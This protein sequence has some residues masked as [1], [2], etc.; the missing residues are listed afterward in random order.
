MTAI[1]TGTQRPEPEAREREEGSIP[2]VLAI[3]VTHN[4]RSWIRDCLVSLA[5]QTYPL[6]D[7]LVVDDASVDSRVEPPLK[8]VVKRHLRNRRWGY[9]RTARPL[10]FGGA[11]NWALS[12]VR[13]DADVL[14]FIHDDAAL[15]P[16]SVER[17]MERLLADDITAVVGPKIV[18]WDDPQRL[19]EVGMAADRFGYPYKG[20]EEG[21]IDLGQHDTPGEVF[22]VTSTCMLVRHDVF[23]QMR[24]WDSR[25]R[26][27]AEDLDLCWRARLMGLVVR[28][29]PRARAR[30][31]IALATSQRPSPFK[32][33]RYYIR[34]NRLRTVFKNASTIRLLGLVPQFILLTLAEMLGFIV[35]RQPGE[36]FNLARA[37]GWNL[38]HIPQTL[39]ERRRVQK[40]RRISDLKLRRLTVRQ[41]KRLRFYIAHQRDRLEEGWGR[42]A[43]VLAARGTQA[44]VLGSQLK[45]WLGVALFFSVV[46][47]LIG[48]RHVWWSPQAA[49][50]EL[51]PY[52]ENGTA[53][54]QA[55]LSP[56][57]AV[58]LGQPGDAP[59]ALA[60]L[61]IFPVA[62]FGAAGAAQKILVLA[63][64][65]LAFKGAYNLVSDLV[66]R[67]GRVAAG[68]IYMLGAVG[69]VG[70]REGALG[71]LVF[72][73][74]APFVLH[75]MVRLGGWARPPGWRPTRSL[76]AV[77]LGAAISAAFV[78]GSLLLYLLVAVLV[79]GIR[80][81]FVQGE[82]ALAGVILSVTG[83][84]AGWALLL[85]WSLHWFSDGGP[86]DLLRSAPTS[87]AYAASFAEHGMASVVLGQTPEG[88]VLF[89]LALPLLGLIAVLAGRGAR[90]RLALA[91]WAVIV[92]MGWVITLMS[93]GSLKP[94]VASPTE[95]G[96]LVS[97]C[98]A[99]LVGLSV[100]AFRLD[101]P[102]RGF[103]WVHWTTLGGFATAIFLVV[104]G[105]GPAVLSGSWAPGR[106]SGRENSEIVAQIRSL[107]AAEAS[108]A[109]RY[110]ALWVGHR[111]APPVRSVMRPVGDTFVTGS[112]GQVMSDQ[113]ER[114]TSR[115]WSRLR[116]V[117]DS[118]ERGDTDRAGAL[119]GAFNVHY[120]VM[121]RGEVDEGWLDQRDL[122]I[123]RA[124][125][126]YLV[127]ENET[128]LPRAGLYDT[129]PS[130]VRAI[131][132]AD[133]TL[134]RSDDELG[135]DSLDSK[136]SANYEDPQAVGPG[137]AF[138]AE[139]ADP[140]WEGQFR[141]EV[142][143]KT[144]SVWGNAFEV[145]SGE[146]KL[147]VQYPRSPTNLLL[148]FAVA[149][150]WIVVTGAAFS[151]RR[152]G[153]RLRTEVRS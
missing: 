76:A 22:Y 34:R 80:G 77:A 14:L 94:L 58:G 134:A 3:V 20:L 127:L 89:G 116:A 75:S 114:V 32:P 117:I 130:F 49:V 136:S 102:R 41:T 23:K 55:F 19:E 24:G 51:L 83:L 113:F 81:L 43:E 128:F 115:G 60:L 152:G 17:M 63:L 98:F 145:P 50:G 132:E 131:D 30:H 72:G 46:A 135:L 137:V 1:A 65:I 21:E 105:L 26:A 69:Y 87:S 142:I 124:E 62:T 29:E 40:D 149:L 112:R 126:D 100:G 59:A 47:L 31:A 35:L 109:G 53:L 10:G 78:P 150:G 73:A 25:L 45:G 27:F 106:G 99:G 95:A 8:R 121:Q 118:V 18:S 38:V 74:A 44:K 111:W 54:W 151:T 48:F 56:W 39:A 4:G 36:I 16:D 146:G 103:G 153:P 138:L 15:D 139:S 90:R 64:G 144:P 110:R 82:R 85:P 66:D 97:A 84:L 67:T 122:A 79:G 96:V 133:P 57:R 93:S 28:L 147:E 119:L 11:I 33:Q 70:L 7:V 91:L 120:I 13:T 141:D 107:L 92:M 12:R 52:P 61:G 6:L 5:V 2:S 68:S 101:L 42:R 71:A 148:L 108:A 104:A 123:V 125:P 88:R 129:M 86:L 9:L 140:A 143:D 37:L